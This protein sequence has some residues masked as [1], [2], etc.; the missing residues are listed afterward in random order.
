MAESDFCSS[1]GSFGS[2]DMPLLICTGCRAKYYCSRNCQKIGWNLHKSECKLIR[3]S[4]E[5][6]ISKLED[7]ENSE[8][9][10]T[11]CENSKQTFNALA[12][13]YLENTAQPSEFTDCLFVKA[14]KT[15]PLRPPPHSSTP[16]LVSNKSYLV[17]SGDIIP[18]AMLR[19][20]NLDYFS[21]VMR[22]IEEMRQSLV[23]IR[24]IMAVVVVENSSLLYVYPIG[25]DDPP[26]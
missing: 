15:K 23:H 21:A 5:V 14:V 25:Y 10:I 6:V 3:N 19:E 11:W 1:C 16:S 8:G 20:I 12:L 7:G 2:A 9:F 26:R 22:G 17:A 13:K 24:A 4:R 18:L